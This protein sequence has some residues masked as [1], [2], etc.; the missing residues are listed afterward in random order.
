M[1]APASLNGEGATVHSRY[2]AYKKDGSI[3]SC[4]RAALVIGG[5][6]AVGVLA[7]CIYY[8]V[9][10]LTSDYW[11][12]REYYESSAIMTLCPAVILGLGGTAALFVAATAPTTG[13]SSAQLQAREV[14]Y[15]NHQ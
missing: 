11:W 4:E 9:P 13:Q 14:D 12:V 3:S 2:E 5:L 1:S 7:Y 8:F 6:I 10:K 15:A